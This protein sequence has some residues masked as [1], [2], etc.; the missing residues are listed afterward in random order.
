MGGGWVGGNFKPPSPCICQTRKAG[1]FK[2]VIMIDMLDISV[3]EQ[4]LTP[5]NFDLV[6]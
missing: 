4:N 1:T 3:F 2:L 5:V 6:H